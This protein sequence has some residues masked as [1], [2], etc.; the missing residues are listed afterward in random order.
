MFLHRPAM[1]SR[2]VRVAAVEYAA[3]GSPKPAPRGDARVA[4]LMAMN[5]ANSGLPT[6]KSELRASDAQLFN[7]WKPRPAPRIHEITERTEDA[8]RQSR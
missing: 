8:R 1:T 2:P 6:T 5:V 3:I 7:V 4:R